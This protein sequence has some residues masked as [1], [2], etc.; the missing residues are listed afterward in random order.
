LKRD[1]FLRPGHEAPA[2]APGAG[3]LEPMPFVLA[4]RS[5]SSHA[6]ARR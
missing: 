5:T 2:L 6:G 3:T 4:G 1:K